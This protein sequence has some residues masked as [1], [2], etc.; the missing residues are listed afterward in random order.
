MDSHSMQYTVIYLLWI[1]KGAVS[2]SYAAFGQG[3]G[4]ILFD[5]VACTGTETNITECSHSGLGVNNCGHYE[6]AG[7]RCQGLLTNAGNFKKV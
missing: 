5:D 7:V 4:M 3:D 6:D 2:F 1:P